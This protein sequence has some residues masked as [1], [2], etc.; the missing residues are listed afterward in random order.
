ME[1]NDSLQSNCFIVIKRREK[2]DEITFFRAT[3]TDYNS[4]LLDFGEED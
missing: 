1:P 2:S 4:K 3:F